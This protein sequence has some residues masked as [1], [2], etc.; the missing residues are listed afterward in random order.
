LIATHS[1]LAELGGDE[2]DAGRHHNC[3]ALAVW[4]KVK[5]RAAK[6]REPQPRLVGDERVEFLGAAKSPLN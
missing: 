3:N 6:S 1:A 2:I 4:R 5:L